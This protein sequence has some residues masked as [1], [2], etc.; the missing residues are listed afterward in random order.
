MEDHDAIPDGGPVDERG[1]PAPG[2]LH[3]SG[4]VG[5]RNGLG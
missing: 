3:I 5:G 4:Q 1:Q 2:V